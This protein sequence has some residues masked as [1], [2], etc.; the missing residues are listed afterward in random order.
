[1]ILSR[2]QW[3]GVFISNIRHVGITLQINTI[4]TTLPLKEF[5]QRGTIDAEIRVILGT[6]NIIPCRGRV[7]ADTSI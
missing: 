1:M 7:Y 6:G 2:F 4:P 5:I 3:S